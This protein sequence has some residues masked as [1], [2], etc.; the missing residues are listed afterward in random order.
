[1]TLPITLYT[2]VPAGK[3]TTPTAAIIILRN[4]V[5]DCNLPGNKLLNTEVDVR[6]QFMYKACTLR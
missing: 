3:P 2:D 5:R 1:M 4:T 6:N